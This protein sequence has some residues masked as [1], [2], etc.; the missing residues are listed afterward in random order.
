MCMDHLPFRVGK[1]TETIVHFRRDT[2]GNSERLLSGISD[3]SLGWKE[4]LSHLKYRSLSLALPQRLGVFVRFLVTING[5][6]AQFFR[7]P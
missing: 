5:H 4:T 2:C 6:V 1:I 7:L 3:R